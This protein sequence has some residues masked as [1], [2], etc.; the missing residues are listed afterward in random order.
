[1]QTTPLIYMNSIAALISYEDGDWLVTQHENGFDVT[2]SF[3]PDSS[4]VA[5]ER[6][7]WA[8]GR[9]NNWSSWGPTIDGRMKPEVVAPGELYNTV[10]L[11]IALQY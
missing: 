8:G 10:I 3:D 7:S 1:M 6:P 2:Y 9:L 11:D 5:A 4:P